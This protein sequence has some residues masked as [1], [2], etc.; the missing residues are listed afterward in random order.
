MVNLWNLPKFRKSVLQTLGNNHTISSSNQIFTVEMDRINIVNAYTQKRKMIK[1]V[2]CAKKSP[3]EN[4]YHMVRSH[5]SILHNKT[6][7]DKMT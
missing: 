7:S 5:G 6:V 2:I 3:E 4:L 1:K